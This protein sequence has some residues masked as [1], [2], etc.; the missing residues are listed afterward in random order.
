[1]NRLIFQTHTNTSNIYWWIY[2][3][4]IVIHR[5]AVSFYQNCSVWLDTQGASSWDPNPPN[6]TPGLVSYRSANSATYVSSAIITH[7]V[8]AFVYLHFALPDTGLLKWE[9][10]IKLGGFWS[11]KRGV[12][13]ERIRGYYDSFLSN[14]T[15][16]TN[17][18]WQNDDRNSLV[19]AIAS[20]VFK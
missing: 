19:T 1:M 17:S 13:K 3:M 11:Q 15:L 2:Y 12:V 8:L 18:L 20:R 7:F 4:Y 9:C 5:Q 6:F 10:A 16:R 14:S